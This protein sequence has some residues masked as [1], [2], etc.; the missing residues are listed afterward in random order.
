MQDDRIEDVT[1]FEFSIKENI[2]TTKF[3][4]TSVEGVAEIEKV[5][6]I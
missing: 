2:V 6:S 1:D 3:K 5:V 4:V